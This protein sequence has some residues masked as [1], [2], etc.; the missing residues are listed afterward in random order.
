MKNKLNTALAALFVATASMTATATEV[1]GTYVTAGA[2]N[3]KADLNSDITLVAGVTVDDEDTVASFTVG[4]QVDENLAVEGGVISSGE[5]S[6][7]YTGSGS[8]TYLGKAYSYSADGSVKA[9]T[10]T[11]YT[12]GLK[13]SSP[14]NDKFDVY[15]KLGMLFWDLEYSVTGNNTFTYDGTAYSI[16]G[17]F[18]KDDGSDVYYGIGTSYAVTEDAAINAEFMKSEVDGA[19]IDGLSLSVGYNF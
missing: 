5:V 1:G 19:D 18:A 2:W 16:G 3:V 10:D 15:G 8:G 7:S 14:I 9:E 12:L 13:Y 11:S 6:V 17:V 4:Y